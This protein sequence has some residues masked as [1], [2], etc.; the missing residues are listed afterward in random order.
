MHPLA[1]CGLLLLF[2]GTGAHAEVAVPPLEAR[3]TDLTATLNAGQRQALEQ[4]LKAF[5]DRKGAQL[6]VLIVPTTEPEAIEQYGIRVVDA[7]RLG[8]KGIDDGLLLLIAKDDRKLRIEVGRGL[9]GVVP[10]AVAKR[11]VAEVITPFF[12]RGD[13][14]GGIEA[15]VNQLVRIIDGE[16]LPPPRQKDMRW[17]DVEDFLWI[18]LFL[19]LAFGGV[20]RSWFGRLSGAGI[21]GGVVGFVFWLIMGSLIGAIVAGIVGFVVTLII[22]LGGGGR[23][24]GGR[25]SSGGYSSSGGGWSGGGGGGFSGGGGSFGGGGAS[26]SW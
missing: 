15:G 3:V 4:E 6:A 2:G 7:W 12:K 9:E 5:E 10:D 20:A 17:S 24:G 21:T 26:G 18:S 13:F 25:W 16:P 1:L 11:V 14:Y 23:G 22:G 19:V 8:R